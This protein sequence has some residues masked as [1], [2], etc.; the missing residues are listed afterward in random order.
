MPTVSHQ[1]EA[2]YAVKTT[3]ASYHAPPS[4]SP[5]NRRRSTIVL[6]EHSLHCPISSKYNMT[7][8]HVGTLIEVLPQPR[9][10]SWK[11]TATNAALAK[12]DKASLPEETKEEAY[13]QIHQMMEAIPVPKQDVR[14]GPPIDLASTRG[15]TISTT[16]FPGSWWGAV[17]YAVCL[18]IHSAFHQVRQL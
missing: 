2:R 18:A 10:L 16:P 1:L 15:Y 9:R 6:T 4:T 12:L 3:S 13:R 7:I 14:V 5:S 8:L 17:A 11:L